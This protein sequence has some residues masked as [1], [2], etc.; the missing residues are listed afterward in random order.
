MAAPPSDGAASLRSLVFA[1][2]AAYGSA[3]ASAPQDA[4]EGALGAA[5]S[6]LLHLQSLL[7]VTAAATPAARHHADGLL[8]QC[9]ARMHTLAVQQLRSS[10]R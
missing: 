5:Q 7:S 8:E 2:E 6:A 9:T 1:A 4:P 10:A 3:R